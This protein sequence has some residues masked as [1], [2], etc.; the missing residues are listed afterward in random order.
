M[1]TRKKSKQA[2]PFFS[3]SNSSLSPGSSSLD[4]PETEVVLIDYCFCSS[5]LT[6][7]T[8]ICSPIIY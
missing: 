2:A 4:S 7:I 3:S 8:E 6:K 1:E 5:P